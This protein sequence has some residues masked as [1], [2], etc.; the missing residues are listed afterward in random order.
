VAA[1]ALESH[2]LT[3]ATERAL[4]SASAA[5]EVG[6]P[7]EAALSRILAGRALARA[8]HRKQA[9]SELARA[10]KTLHACGAL[11]YRDQ[12]EQ[13]LRQLGHRI[14]RRTRPGKADG[15]GVELLTERELQIARLVVDRQTNPEIA[16]G[17]FLSK[18]TIESHMHNMFQKLGIGSRV[19]LARAVE[20]ADRTRSAL[21]GSRSGI[22]GS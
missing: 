18:K 20:Q 11:G 12:A 10:A 13:E 4:A 17:L 22:E 21:S 15:I 16:A 7:V 6:V 2:D 5:D 8:G 14:H 1:V 19:E 9:A 3:T